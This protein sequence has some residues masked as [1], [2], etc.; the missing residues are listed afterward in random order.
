ML[1]AVWGKTFKSKNLCFTGGVALNCVANGR[2]RSET[3]YAQV[4]I[5][6]CASDTGVPF[7]SALWHYHQTLGYPRTFALTHA[8]YGTEYGDR[9]VTEAFD[10]A[11]LAYERLSEADLVG[12]VAHDL[13]ANKIVGWFQG[14]CEIGPRALGNR[15]ILASPLNKH[16]KEMMNARIKFRE[17][18]R[19]FAPAVLIEHAAKYFEISGDDPF[20]TVAV[21]V[22]AGKG[23]RD[24]VRGSCRWHCPRA[25]G[26][27][28]CKSALLRGD[29][30]IWKTN[31]SAGYSEHELQ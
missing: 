7:G 21:R 13:A 24:P 15:S 11:G 30:S 2:V 19:P 9:A 26:G 23:G 29:R 27:S 4:W 31:R 25:N 17:P 10:R 5:P 8:F 20:M 18:F 3:D 12:R 1:S 22:A 16:V 6:P 28:N 14:R